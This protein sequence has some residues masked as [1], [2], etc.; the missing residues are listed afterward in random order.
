MFWQAK[1]TDEIL[2]YAKY[3]SDWLDAKQKKAKEKLITVQTKQFQSGVRK[4]MVQMQG[5]C[6]RGMN[7]HSNINL[8]K[9]NTTGHCC[10]R[11]GY[12]RQKCK[13]NPDQVLNSGAQA[14]QFQG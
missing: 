5:G 6:G 7:A 13:Y 8:L 4:E 12:W 3:S 10:G 9:K 1:G 11:M 2:K 14:N